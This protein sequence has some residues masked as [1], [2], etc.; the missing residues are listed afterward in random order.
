MYQGTH[1]TQVYNVFELI[2]MS[3]F[4]LWGGELKPQLKT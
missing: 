4:Y 3:N 1:N 2:T